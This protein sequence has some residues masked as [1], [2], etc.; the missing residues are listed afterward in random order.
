MNYMYY[1]YVLCG[2][3]NYIILH[4]LYVHIMYAELIAID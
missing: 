2:T 3:V 1:I 4:A